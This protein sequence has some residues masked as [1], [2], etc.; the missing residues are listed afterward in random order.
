MAGVCRE[1]APPETPFLT[2]DGGTLI[3]KTPVM[4]R[5]NVLKPTNE[6]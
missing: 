1:T 2:S 3:N 4:R 6:E 5:F